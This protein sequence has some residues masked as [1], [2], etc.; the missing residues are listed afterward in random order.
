ME[1][2]GITISMFIPIATRIINPHYFFLSQQ[3]LQLKPE[4]ISQSVNFR[5]VSASCKLS[6]NA[7]QSSVQNFLLLFHIS[8]HFLIPSSHTVSESINSFIPTLF[9]S[10]GRFDK[11]RE[12]LM[13]HPREWLR[14]VSPPLFPTCYGARGLSRE[15]LRSEP[16]HLLSLRV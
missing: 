13:Q 2:P 3:S 8:K 5:V 14:E 11:I 16:S 15:D 1:I 12:V 9:P 7:I 10:P 4:I 6:V